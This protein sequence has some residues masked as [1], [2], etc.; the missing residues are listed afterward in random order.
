MI[1]WILF[2]SLLI[3]IS[4]YKSRVNVLINVLFVIKLYVVFL[5]ID[6]VCQG[7]SDLWV[8]ILYLFLMEVLLIV[9]LI[10]LFLG[11]DF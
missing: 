5:F 6:L 11:E 10:L 8:F 1:V 4:L 9:I 7:V 2:I 3:Y